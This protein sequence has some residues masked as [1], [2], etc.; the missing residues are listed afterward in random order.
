MDAATQWRLYHNTVSCSYHVSFTASELEAS[1]LCSLDLSADEEEA[2]PG[3]RLQELRSGVEKVLTGLYK[4]AA[5]SRALLPRHLT[6]AGSL[7]LQPDEGEGEPTGTHHCQALKPSCALA[8][9]HEVVSLPAKELV[10]CLHIA[11]L[12]VSDGVRMY[13]LHSR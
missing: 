11:L 8:A 4:A 9:H 3:I 7:H 6:F 10:V 2:G 13:A 12:A 5:A 1:L